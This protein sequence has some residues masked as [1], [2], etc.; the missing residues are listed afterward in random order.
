[1]KDLVS[2]VIPTY[3]RAQLLKSAALPSVAAQTYA[4]LECIVV[5]SG[6]DDTAAI[7]DKF[8][9]QHP[10]IPT[11]YI[12][13]KVGVGAARNI[14]I[15]AARGAWILPLDSD[16]ALLPDAIATLADVALREHGDIVWGKTWRV[17]R[18]QKKI[19]GIGGSTP[20]SV[21]LRK[22]IF[23]D[24]GLY[25]EDKELSED[26]D[27]FYRLQ[28]LLTRGVIKL[29]HT[30]IPTSI[31]FI[32][33]GQSVS[34]GN[35]VRN[36]TVAN[37]MLKK[38]GGQE[39]LDAPWTAN[40]ARWWRNK[41]SYEILLGKRSEGLQ[42]IRRSF[43]FQFSWGT[44]GVLAVGFFG[45]WA[46]RTF[47]VRPRMFLEAVSFRVSWLTFLAKHRDIARGNVRA[48]RDILRSDI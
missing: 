21:L 30:D 10:E 35:P 13:K 47:I 11:R 43:S 23:D 15:T 2:I 28:P 38:W 48:V 9:K 36:L 24:Y 17:M 16:D 5:D 45:R 8:A 44:V 41:G 37:G 32:H 1:M 22:K 27:H 42:S 18:G 31:Y 29:V 46:L 6:S 26:V 39:V 12:Y 20:A 25:D 3:N 19:L 4:P 34:L 40:M 7:V 14:A 33:D